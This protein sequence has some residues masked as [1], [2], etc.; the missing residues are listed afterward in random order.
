MMPRRGHTGISDRLRELNVQSERVRA[1]RR[2][3]PDISL[4]VAS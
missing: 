1:A 2:A 4:G 3:R